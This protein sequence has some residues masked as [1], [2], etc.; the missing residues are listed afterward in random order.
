M[1]FGDDEDEDFL[2]EYVGS[3]LRILVIVRSHE[4][5][6][7]ST[8]VVIEEIQLLIVLINVCASLID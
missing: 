4:F 5:C 2:I 7:H 3:E 8:V 1:R 6:R